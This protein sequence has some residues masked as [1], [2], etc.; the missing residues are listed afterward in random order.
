[1]YEFEGKTSGIFFPSLIL[2]VICFVLGPVVAMPWAIFATVPL[3]IALIS[4]LARIRPRQIDLTDQG[5]EDRASF[6]SIAFSD[7]NGIW[8]RGINLLNHKFQPADRRLVIEYSGGM[9]DLYDRDLAKLA[10]FTEQLLSRVK[11]GNSTALQAPF[12]NQYWLEEKGTFGDNLIQVFR[13]APGKINKSR[14]RDVSG[15]LAL[16]CIPIS[17]ILWTIF[18]FLVS[19]DGFKNN[20]VMTGVT[21][22]HAVIF[23]IVA[24]ISTIVF[25][26]YRGK[27][28]SRGKNAA[29]VISPRGFAL[30]QNNLDGSITWAE[31][32]GIKK[33][34]M[35]VIVS[36][37]GATIIILDIYD[38]PADSI[39]HAMKANL[40]R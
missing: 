19:A 26:A 35:G 10:S 9:L 22:L 6:L 23:S 18:G 16:V 4:Y 29:L 5:L 30:A 14:S 15:P 3:S 1:M 33:S 7:I 21:M 40:S 12:V 38:L 11:P 28:S 20:E 27:Y 31:V 32:K 36:I 2:T 17:I 13:Q 8:S 34:R 39:F 24:V 37:A 25:I